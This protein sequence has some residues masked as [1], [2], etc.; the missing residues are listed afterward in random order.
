MAFSADKKKQLQAKIAE[1]E[2]LK[3]DPKF[4]QTAM[5]DKIARSPGVQGILG[6]GD[7][8][9]NQTNALASLLSF[10]KIPYKPTKSGEGVAY[11][12]GKI[13]MEIAEMFIPTSLPG[14]LGASVGASVL[15]DPENLAESTGEGLIFG[16]AGEAISPVT[17]GAGSLIRNKVIEP[18]SLDKFSQEI[19]KTIQ[20]AYKSAEDRAWGTVGPILNKFGGEKL[21]KPGP[22][23][24]TT[25]SAFKQ[26]SSMYKD[27]EDLFTADF[28]KVKR[29]FD[30]APTIG[31]A[32]KMVK[33]LGT[34]ERKLMY[35]LEEGKNLKEK[36]YGDSKEA[37]RSVLRPRMEELSPGFTEQYNT[38]NKTFAK[39]V[40]PFLSGKTIQSAAAGNVERAEPL[41]SEIDKLSKEK[42]KG[43]PAI[44]EEHEL[45]E[46]QK[47]M[48]SKLGTA[49]MVP[50]GASKLAP[51]FGTPLSRESAYQ[52]G[53]KGV[54]T[55]SPYLRALL[56]SQNVPGV[57]K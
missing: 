24:E 29:E 9:K 33:Q 55:L 17:K 51:I 13:G 30:K 27:K 40:G 20:N 26:F 8:L 52:M 49:Q 4:Q 37:I 11:D 54:D 42:I 22:Y 47:L 18:L 34:D 50:Q 23:G 35:S 25:E 5:L 31:N 57:N 41:Y 2:N 1:L 16:L 38:A 14:R 7:T 45:L 44:G 19:S 36:T 6:A 28:D 32:Q 56:Q 12:V 53:N 21:L 15:S 3:K 39:E 48:G 46:L 10:G 43:Y